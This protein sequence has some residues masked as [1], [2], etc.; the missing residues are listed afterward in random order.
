MTATK[1]LLNRA[2]GT[3]DV[4]NRRKDPLIRVQKGGAM[5][6]KIFSISSQE[7]SGRVGLILGGTAGAFLFWSW[8]QLRHRLEGLAFARL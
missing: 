3:L 6:I 5:R 7:K 1:L 2:R 8:R 4:I